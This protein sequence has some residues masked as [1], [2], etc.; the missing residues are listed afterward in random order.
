MDPGQPTADGLYINYLHIGNLVIVPQFNFK[1][2]DARAL[3][4]FK[5]IFGSKNSVVP[6][7]SRRIA[8][9]GGVL[10]CASW[11]VQL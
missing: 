8:E 11:T 6:Y 10:N 7:D 5:E 4:R 3:A 1:K 9:G 2:E